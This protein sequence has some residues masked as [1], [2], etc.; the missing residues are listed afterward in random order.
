MTDEPSR[1]GDAS[2]SLTLILSCQPAFLDTAEAL[3]SR[4]GEHAGC[5]RDDARRLGRAVRQ[6]LGSLIEHP[7]TDRVPRTL[8]VAF[9]GNG[10]LLEVD[11]ACGLDNGAP[12]GGLEESLAGHGDDAVMRALVDRVEFVEEGERQ[13]CRLTQQVRQTSPP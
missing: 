7:P 11:V 5:S 1:Q 10:R 13:L 6:A 12:L 2:L 3:V 8:E 4:V 9:Q